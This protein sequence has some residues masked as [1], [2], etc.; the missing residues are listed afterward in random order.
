MDLKDA[1]P[2]L[3]VSSSS[4]SAA[5]TS[6]A[7]TSASA[8]AA[9]TSASSAVSARLSPSPTEGEAEDTVVL[10][11][12]VQDL[13][14]EQTN[15]FAVFAVVVMVFLLCLFRQVDCLRRQLA[16]SPRSIY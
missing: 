14:A 4:P 9:A 10:R 8:S 16:E 5:A 7:A 3:A 2:D 1:W 12:L 11:A 6:A 13:R 15:R